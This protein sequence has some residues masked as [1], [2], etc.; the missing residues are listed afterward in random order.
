MPTSLR[1]DDA[2]FI[3]SSAHLNQA[4]TQ[5]INHFTLWSQGSGYPFLARTDGEL[6]K[7]RLFAEHIRNR[8]KGL[9][10]L[11]IGG[12]S[13]GGE[14]LVK[15]LGKREKEIHFFDNVDPNTL[16]QLEQFYWPDFFLLVISKSGGTAETLSQ[17]LSLL[18][19]LQNQL[20][21]GL[22]QHVAVITEAMGGALG[23]IATEL[24]IPII[25]HLAIGGRYSV[26]SVV[27]LLPAAVDGVDIEQLLQGAAAMADRC[28]IP[29]PI[30]NP[31]WRMGVA[32]YQMAL[33]GKN[34]SI[35]MAYGDRLTRICAWLGQLWA[36]S[37]GK[38]DPN[39]QRRGLT[40][41]A[42]R[43]VTDQHSQ[44]QLYLD[45]PQDKQFTL[46]YDPKLAEQGLVIP[47]RFGHLEAVAPLVGHRTGALF[48]A[49][50]MGTRDA[51][52]HQALPVRTFYLP[53]GAA[54]PLGELILLLEAE[55]TVVAE[56]FAINPFDQPAVEESKIRAR[57]Y[58]EKSRP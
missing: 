16:M 20:G 56:C 17:F 12:S 22:K 5:F 37:L 4:F 36:E 1:I 57:A 19:L 52:I 13:L 2:S 28:G 3:G 47:E 43:G 49:E 24:E 8:A 7:A 35:H 41:V 40:P 58:L 29:D 39:N 50:F 14:M 6:R 48:A 53:G 23:E 11:G 32:Q 38:K 51:L 26:L 42:A 55:T 45:G 15:T 18:P 10:I 46:F 27:G 30:D 9:V 21:A 34:I 31:A 25:P 33:A 54:Y 44:L